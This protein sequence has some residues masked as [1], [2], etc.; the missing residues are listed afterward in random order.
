MQTVGIRMVD[1][2]GDIGG[3]EGRRGMV[4]VVETI[5]FC[6]GKERGD[7]GSLDILVGVSNEVAERMTRNINYIW[8][9]CCVGDLPT[10]RL[11]IGAELAILLRVR[12]IV[13]SVG[14]PQTLG[15]IVDVP[16]TYCDFMSSLGRLSL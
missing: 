3:V 9:S 1:R 8:Y 16:I 2:V 10:L 5:A 4:D 7:G 14:K 11:I 13:F 6:G 12:K 15:L